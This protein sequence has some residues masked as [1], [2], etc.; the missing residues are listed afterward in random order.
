MSGEPFH[1]CTH[2]AL[3]PQ[4]RD[5][6]LRRL[7]QCPRAQVHA[8]RQADQELGRARH[9]SRPVQHRAQ[10]R[11]RCRRLGLCR[12]PREPPRAGVRRQR[13]IRD[14]VEQSAPP[15]RAVLLRRRQESDVSSSASSARA[16]RSTARCPISA[17]GFRIVDAKGMRIAR[18]GGENGPGVES[19]KFLAPHGLALDSSG[20][21]YVGEV[22]VTDWKTSFPDEAMPAEVGG[23]GVCR[24]WRRFRRRPSLRAKRNNLLRHSALIF[25][26]LMIGHQRS[27]SAF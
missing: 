19:G 10:Y 13:Q 9:R 4:G 7:W 2:T 12:R 27:A 15:L 22:G 1:R 24:S 16:W 14:A 20:D 3:S 17:R 25:A 21:I 18:L 5:L 11:D 23:R 8:R 26:A 6:R